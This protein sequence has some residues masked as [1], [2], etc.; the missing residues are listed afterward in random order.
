M[1]GCVPFEAGSCYTHSC[2]ADNP[3]GYLALTIQIWRKLQWQWSQLRQWWKC[4]TKQKNSW[5]EMHRRRM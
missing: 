5:R 3:A 4:G 2:L 1:Q